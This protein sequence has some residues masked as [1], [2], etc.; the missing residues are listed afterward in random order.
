M[1]GR[2]YFSLF[3]HHELTMQQRATCPRQKKRVMYMAGHG[4][5]PP[6]APRGQTPL[7]GTLHPSLM[8][9]AKVAFDAAANR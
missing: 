1:R 2:S 6:M 4:K 9:A 8:R 3:T 5:V 7:L